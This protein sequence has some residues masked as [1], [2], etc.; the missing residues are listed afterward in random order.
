M[1]IV[2]QQVEYSGKSVVLVFRWGMLVNVDSRARCMLDDHS[3][4]LKVQSCWSSG[5]VREPK[6]SS[7][8]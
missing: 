2:E 8:Q 1:I 5:Q 7:L 4:S 6:D 3:R